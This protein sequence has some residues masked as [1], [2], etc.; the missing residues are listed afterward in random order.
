MKSAALIFLIPFILGTA[1][2]A[3]HAI[4]SSGGNLYGS[5][6]KVSY[7]VGIICYT[8]Q[9]SISAKILQG[10][11]FPY[12]VYGLGISDKGNPGIAVDFYPNPVTDHLIVAI[13]RS[14]V[15]RL[16][17]QIYDQT[18]K[19]AGGK[20]LKDEKTIIPMS[21]LPNGMYLIKI[22]EANVLVK[23]FLIIKK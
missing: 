19:I 3:Q 4:V 1:L 6:G 17:Y 10:I 20:A 8:S 22:A 11:Q 12:E 13:D 7:S 23:S 16:S 21:Y 2:Q 5:D 14:E 18:G 9:T 15:H